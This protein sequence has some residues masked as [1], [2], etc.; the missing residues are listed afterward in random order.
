MRLAVCLAGALVAAAA[1]PAIA[2]EPPPV[3]DLAAAEKDLGDARK[4]VLFH[5]EGV[6]YQDALR[7]ITACASH[8]TRTVQRTAPGFVPWGRDDQ[9]SPITYDGGNF[10]LVGSVIGSIIDGPIERS[11]RQTTMIRCMTPRGYVR[12]RAS[13][14][15][16][17]ELFEKRDDWIPLAAAIA[18]A[19]TGTNE[20]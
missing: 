16:W 14:D 19:A 6:S 9:G 11:I 12:Y 7:D 20:S 13:K 17:Q 15:Q 5:K 3:P 1:A 2:S 10:G 4:Y 8:G 18:S